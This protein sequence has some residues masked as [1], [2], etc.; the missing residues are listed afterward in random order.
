VP[1]TQS[2]NE[3]EHVPARRRARRQ[4]YRYPFLD[5][6]LQLRLALV[7]TVVSV[8]N[9]IFFTL[10]LAFYSKA[11]FLRMAHWLPDYVDA[12]DLA[13]VQFELWPRT[14]TAVVVFEAVAIFA[15]GL[16]FSHRIAGPAYALKLRLREM[17]RGKIP[18]PVGLRRGSFLGPLVEA[19]N[20]MNSA[21]RARHVEMRTEL[22]TAL[23]ELG[24]GKKEQAAKRLS[25]Y[26]HE[27]DR[28]KAPGATQRA[29]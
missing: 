21:L 12:K 22:E 28:P 6:A 20:E 25:D 9:A 13:H 29:S 26:L 23:R 1:H 14:L 15:F 16:F 24:E 10:L 18:D 8:A 17:V 5:P 2:K 19:F 27:L 3:P 4:W 7:P 11:S